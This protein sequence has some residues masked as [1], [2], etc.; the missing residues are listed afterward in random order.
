VRAPSSS[1]LTTPI[2]ILLHMKNSQESIK[3][4]AGVC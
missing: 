3:L 4:P 2:V 1:L